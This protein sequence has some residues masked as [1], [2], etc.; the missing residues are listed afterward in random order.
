MTESQSAFVSASAELN[1]EFLDFQSEAWVSVDSYLD[2][3]DRLQ[4]VAEEPGLALRAGLTQDLKELGLFGW[5]LVVS[6]T[7]WDALRQA[8]EALS[9]MQ[10]SGD[11]SLTIRRERCRIEYCNGY[12]ASAEADLDTQ[13]AV[14]LFINLI[15]QTVGYQDSNLTVRYPRFRV[16]HKYLLHDAKVVSSA[17][18]G[19]IEFDAHLLRR[20]L[21]QSNAGLSATLNDTLPRFEGQT[22]DNFLLIQE[23]QVSALSEM[24]APITLLDMASLLGVPAR[25]LQW[26]LKRL[27]QSFA[28]IRTSARHKAAKQNLTAG[29]SV[30]ETALLLGYSHQQTFSNAFARWEGVTTSEFLS[31]ARR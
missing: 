2:S 1:P 18:R 24:Q 13:L 3:F 6:E 28:G 23:L 22:P 19:I 27:G 9:Y 10:N 29:R 21:A 30:G 16:G 26:D 14:G 4:F 17:S 20:P 31:R 15:R 7:L 11:I 5:C 12:G 25:S 8:Q